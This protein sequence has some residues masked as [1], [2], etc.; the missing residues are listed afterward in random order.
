MIAYILLTFRYRY[1]NYET[2]G[3]LYRSVNADWLRMTLDKR[4]WELF[5]EIVILVAIV[6]DVD[7]D[8]FLLK[9]LTNPEAERL[10]EL[11]ALDRQSSAA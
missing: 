11:L 10:I 3:K 9:V 4:I 1:D 6:I 5:L 8:D 2:M 7:A